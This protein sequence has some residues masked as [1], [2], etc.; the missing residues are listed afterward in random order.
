MATF[1]DMTNE[2]LRRINEVPIVE[3]DF[4]TTR[5]VQG[6]AKDAVN[7]SIRHI[8]Q[9]AQQW[10]YAIIVYDQV[11]V[12]GTREYNFPA[13]LSV[14]DYESFYIKPDTTLNTS[15]GALGQMDHDQYQRYYR[16]ADDQ[17][18]SGDFAEPTHVYK[19]QQ[20]KFGLTPTPDKTYTVE[21]KYWSFPADLSAATDTPIIPD[22][23]KHVIVEGAMVFLMRFRSNE[24][25]AAMHEKKFEDG[26]NMM[27]R[28]LQQPVSQV[29]S[30]VVNKNTS[31]I[32][33][34]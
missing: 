14:I 33:N 15:G 29:T 18:V 9:S 10:P 7:N 27:R 17:R 13:D 23:F 2:V 11:L 8:L 25:A 31:Y 20:S 12:A 28:L 4:S 21:Y 16:A 26:I 5:N 1:L 19:T 24:Q 32:V 22:R 30:T 3:A 34:V 6:L